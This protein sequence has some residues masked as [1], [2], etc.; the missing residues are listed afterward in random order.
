MIGIKIKYNIMINMF[1]IEYNEKDNIFLPQ[2]VI[3]DSNEKNTGVPFQNTLEI[4]YKKIN[5]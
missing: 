1:D 4:Q 3:I 2:K 5:I